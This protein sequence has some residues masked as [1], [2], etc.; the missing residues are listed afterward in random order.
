MISRPVVVSPVKA[1]LRIR[2]LL[3]SGLPAST[4]KPLTTLSTPARQQVADQL[5]QLED[6]PRSLLGGLEHHGVAGREGGR[7]LPDRHQ[8]REVPRD[9]LADDAQRLVEVVGDR[10]LVDLGD[11]ALLGAQGAGEVA[12]VVDGQ[13]HVRVERL[14][15]GLAVVPRLDHRE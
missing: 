12:E 1:I 13:R 2:L 7:E 11:A 8:D 5:H 15:H 3:A 4:P 9:D 10:V 14:A 6:R